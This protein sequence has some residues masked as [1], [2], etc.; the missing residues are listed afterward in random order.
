MNSVKITYE[1]KPKKWRI[2]LFLGDIEFSNSL[3]GEKDGL[4]FIQMLT[5]NMI[6]IRA[7][8]KDMNNLNKEVK[9]A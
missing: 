1:A 7:A 6:A 3:Y 8:E 4:D 5:Y 2:K 9:N